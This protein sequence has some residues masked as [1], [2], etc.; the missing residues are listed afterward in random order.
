VTPFQTINAAPTRGKEV[1]EGKIFA[2][3]WTGWFNQ[4]VQKLNAN[5]AVEASNI[6]A[7]IVTAKLTTGGAE[8][9]MTFVD[10]RLTA[11]TQAT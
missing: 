2:V 7:V 11:Q 5:N 9:S 8:G 6:S 10:G 4:L 3:W 1:L